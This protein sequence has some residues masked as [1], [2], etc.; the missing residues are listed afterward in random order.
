MPL[1][2]MVGDVVDES[3]ELPRASMGS[4]SSPDAAYAETTRCGR[5]STICWPPDPA[6]PWSYAPL[7]KTK[8]RWARVIG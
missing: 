4:T 3:I 7:G 2:E 5:R 8:P 1:V 6:T